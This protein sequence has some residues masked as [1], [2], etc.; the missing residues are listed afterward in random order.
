MRQVF[1]TLVVALAAQGP[2]AAVQGSQ[3]ID[4]WGIGTPGASMLEYSVPSKDFAQLPQWDPEK[5]PP[6][7]PI[8]RAVSL[9]KKA[10]RAEH[11]DWREDETLLWSVELQQAQSAEYPKR[12]FYVFMFRRMMAE[13]PLPRG[14]ATIVVLM[15]GSVVKPKAGRG[16]PR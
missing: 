11:S 1:L 4:L 7:F 5:D 3:E 9:A 10:L 16:V 14:E 6:P 12:W 15:N 13:Q 2:A 8:S